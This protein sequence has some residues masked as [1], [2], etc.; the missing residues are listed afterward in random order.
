M[1]TVIEPSMTDLNEDCFRGLLIRAGE[2]PAAHGRMAGEEGN[3]S[4]TGKQT[5]C[6]FCL[7]Q[8]AYPPGSGSRHSTGLD[9]AH[10]RGANPGMA[11]HHC[12]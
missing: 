5:G 6:A 12:A 11:N 8:L 1:D 10:S 3:I 9:F 4:L 7:Y 2:G